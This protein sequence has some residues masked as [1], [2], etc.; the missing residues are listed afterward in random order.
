MESTP[1]DGYF[2]DDGNE[3][4]SLIQGLLCLGGFVQAAG[5]SK[6]DRKGRAS[7]QGVKELREV[8]NTSR[9][10][11]D[12]QRGNRERSGEEPDRGS[13]GEI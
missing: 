9:Q 2:T 6:R 5:L 8:R 12:P 10:G 1:S 7:K 13:G 3:I 4:A 11:A